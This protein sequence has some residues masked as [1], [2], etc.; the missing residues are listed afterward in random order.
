[1]SQSVVDVWITIAM[2]VLGYGLRK[3]GFEV[4][5]SCSATSSPRR[6]RPACASRSPCSYAIV[7][8]RPTAAGIFAVAAVVF[9]LSM[10]TVFSRKQDWRAR[11]G[12]GERAR[13]GLGEVDGA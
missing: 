7:S 1:V 6:S 2:G 9:A 8:Q 4:A 10:R 13:F 3:L 5:L 12:L 11:F